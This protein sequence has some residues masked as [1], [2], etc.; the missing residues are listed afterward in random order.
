MKRWRHSLDRTMNN[1]FDFSS[2]Y[3]AITVLA[4][5]QQQELSFMA[6]FTVSTTVIV[7]ARLAERS[8]GEI[9][10]Y[11]HAVGRPTDLR[12]CFGRFQ[13]ESASGYGRRNG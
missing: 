8:C 7:C 11:Q 10:G 3:V 1:S 9:S 2:L 13:G 5:H 12:A 4:I 6:Q